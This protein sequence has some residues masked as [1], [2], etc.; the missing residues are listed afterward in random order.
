M[1]FQNQAIAGADADHVMTVEP[2]GIIGP[3]ETKTLR[4]TLRDRAWDEE[5][6]ISIGQ[7]SMTVAGS[8]IFD[9]DG[10]QPARTTVP[11][12]TSLF[13]TRFKS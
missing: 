10:W 3:G 9:E 2:L 5:R 12:V 13:P 4:L 7:P 1:S 8:L 11:I 6:L